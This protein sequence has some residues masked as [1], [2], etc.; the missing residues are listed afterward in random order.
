ML[1]Q[2]FFNIFLIFVF[3]DALRL[4]LRYS[5]VTSSQF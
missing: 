5:G 2:T 3:I 1:P 4:I